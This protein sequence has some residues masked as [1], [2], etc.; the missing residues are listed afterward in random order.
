MKKWFILALV[1]AVFM[2]TFP[3]CGGDDGG[4]GSASNVKALVDDESDP[5]AILITW[6][7]SDGY[8]YRVYYQVLNDLSPAAIVDIGLGQNV[9][10]YDITAEDPTIGAKNSSKSKW[11]YLVE[12]T[13]STTFTAIKTAATTANE[14]GLVRFGV[15]PANPGGFPLENE[16][17]IV[18]D[19]DFVKLDPQD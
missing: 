13:G 19:K 8:E 14:E 18:W 2:V 1:A 10:E 11:Q 4:V 7:A 15:G 5:G 17:T 9:F 12:T 6:N 16:I 3:A